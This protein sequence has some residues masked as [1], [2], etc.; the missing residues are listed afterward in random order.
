[1]HGPRRTP[2]SA[3]YPCTGL[4]APYTFWLRGLYP[5]APLPSISFGGG[6]MFLPCFDFV[7]PTQPLMIG[8][9]WFYSIVDWTTQSRD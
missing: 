4:S 8:S 3:P 6:R 7:F 1:M 2:Y 9:C 5:C